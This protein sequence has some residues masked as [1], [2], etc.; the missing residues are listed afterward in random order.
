MSTNTDEAEMIPLRQRSLRQREASAAKF[1]A[2]FTGRTFDIVREVHLDEGQVFVT[3]FGNRGRHGYV[4]RD[5][6]SGEEMV[7]GATML[8]LIHD[9]YLGVSLPSKKRKKPAE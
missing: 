4:I 9:R 8:K 3:R 5:R 1:D 2:V 7:V 6:E